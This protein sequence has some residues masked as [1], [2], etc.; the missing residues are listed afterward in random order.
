MEGIGRWKGEGGMKGG[1]RSEGGGMEGG[2]EDWGWS[3]GR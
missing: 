3:D 2:R 1:T